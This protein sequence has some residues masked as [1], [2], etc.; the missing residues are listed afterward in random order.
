MEAKL[1]IYCFSL[2]VAYSLFSLIIAIV[3]LRSNYNVLKP[4]HA[5]EFF[6]TFSTVSI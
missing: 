5:L 3:Y 4:S 2:Y 6:F 1:P